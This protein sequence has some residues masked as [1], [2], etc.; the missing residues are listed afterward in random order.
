L[1]L[2]KKTTPDPRLLSDMALWRRFAAEVPG[3]LEGRPDFRVDPKIQAR[4]RKP[5]AE[6]S[7][8]NLYQLLSQ[9]MPRLHVVLQ[10]LRR[11]DDAVLAGCSDELF[12][13]LVALGPPVDHRFS[14]FSAEYYLA[15]R[16]RVAEY[17]DG[18]F[19]HYLRL[20]RKGKKPG[21]TTHLA[22]HVR[23]LGGGEALPARYVL[24]V[25]DGP[26]LPATQALGLLMAQ[27]ARGEGLGVIHL[28]DRAEM[29][30][31]QALRPGDVVCSTNLVDLQFQVTNLLP[32][33]AIAFA[34]DLTL[35][36]PSLYPFAA[37]AG[38]PVLKIVSFGPNLPVH[39]DSLR[40]V[41]GRGGKL[42]MTTPDLV[43]IW[44]EWMDDQLV[45]SPQIDSPELSVPLQWPQGGAES[46]ESFDRL[47][48][49]H[50]GADWQGRKLILCAGELGLES[51]FD[52]AC[53]LAGLLQRRGEAA[54]L[55][56]I[57]TPSLEHNRKAM[58]QGLR[59]H[60]RTVPSNMAVWHRPSALAEA[61]RHCTA[62]LALDRMP[63]EQS[64][65]VAAFAAGKPV[66][67]FD[68]S[69]NLGRIAAR[70]G[71]G[72]RFHQ[73]AMG[74]LE[75]MIAFVQGTELSHGVA[76]QD[77]PD[78]LGA[79]AD[80]ALAAGFA[81]VDDVRPRDLAEPTII[82][83]DWQEVAEN[84]E[85][86]TNWVHRTMHLAPPEVQHVDIGSADYSIHHHIH[87]DD[88]LNESLER[89]AEAY[90]RAKQVVMT[91]TTPAM[92]DRVAC[93]VADRIPQARVVLVENCGRDILPFLRTLSEDF[94]QAPEMWWCHIHQKR[95]AHTKI[96]VQWRKFLFEALLG[97]SDG[98]GVSLADAGLG[99]VSPTDAHARHW[100]R[101]AHLRPLVEKG[102]D[103]PLPQQPLLFPV[104]NMF[105]CRGKVALAMLDLFGEDY[106]WPEEPIAM[107]GTEYHL[108]ERLWPS[109]AAKLGLESRFFG[110]TAHSG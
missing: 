100:R 88:G 83:R 75:G 59:G 58:P 64:P 92:R 49:R 99:L 1:P 80:R 19:A 84:L 70:Y 78:G 93:A 31:E 54:N 76:A 101:S 28:S 108:I 6:G 41:M 90:G 45:L 15:Q 95:S 24:L 36:R 74:D 102:F 82:W 68:S 12:C 16:P 73:R 106:P 87:F 20:G 44:S 109:V 91:V 13:E 67:C 11:A 42:L 32:E 10:G 9:K 25:Q 22:D 81:L 89:Y 33:A 27:K 69:V 57:A 2:L 104:G 63:V 107:D 4:S 17:A 50:F 96:G 56:W 38:F 47:M 34:L 40:Y 71:K 97:Q 21:L 35:Q 86:S 43:Q 29:L 39:A 72:H 85:A 30:P 26:V 66:A 7:A 62:F 18:A 79:F 98:A 77:I 110:F 53:I 51:G 3:V 55:L 52:M 65:A 105:F 5:G 61:T 94:R 48:R 60:L 8:A 37:K 46:A 23:L 103:Q 14:H